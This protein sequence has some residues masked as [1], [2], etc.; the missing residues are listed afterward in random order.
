MLITEKIIYNKVEVSVSV[1][2]AKDAA[3][4][5]NNS[6]KNFARSTRLFRWSCL[7]LGD[8]FLSWLL[9]STYALVDYDQNQWISCA[10]YF[11]AF[12]QIVPSSSYATIHR[13]HQHYQVLNF[14]QWLSLVMLTCW[15]LT[16]S[17]ANLR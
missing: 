8:E 16:A 12:T 1:H 15:Y 13:N 2:Y 4:R 7:A 3:L 5:R 11:G 9:R 10:N 17:N 14:V 6:S